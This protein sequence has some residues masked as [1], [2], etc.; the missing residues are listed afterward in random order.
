M[1]PIMAVSPR[2]AAAFR[3]ACAGW[4]VVLS[5]LPFTAPFRTCDASLWFA[6]GAMPARSAAPRVP[7]E[8]ASTDA[9][10]QPSLLT[11]T[12]GRARFPVLTVRSEWLTIADPA[13]ARPAPSTTAS[14]PGAHSPRLAV[15]QI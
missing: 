11:V 13:V 9:F 10:P 5:V 8:A 7:A 2:L 14:D 4:L 15:L 12:A 3:A 1:I 6:G